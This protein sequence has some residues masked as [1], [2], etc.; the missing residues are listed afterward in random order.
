MN[1]VLRLKAIYLVKYTPT[2]MNSRLL[3]ENS[4]K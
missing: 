4:I 1:I 2:N 3:E